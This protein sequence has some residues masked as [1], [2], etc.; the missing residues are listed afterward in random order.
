M[1]PQAVP[2]ASPGGQQPPLPG[3]Q[4]VETNVWAY[5]PWW[6]QPW[7]ILATGAAVV[8]AAWALSGRSPGWTTAAALPVAAWWA[9]FLVLMPAQFR[10]YAEAENAMLRQAQRQTQQ[11]QEQQEEQ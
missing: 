10:E 9:L 5:K 7:S 1:S 6:C 2:G 11:R 8:G 4:L 3:P